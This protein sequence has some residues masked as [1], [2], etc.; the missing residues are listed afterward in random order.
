MPFDVPLELAAA[1]RADACRLCTR[2]PSPWLLSA[3][4]PTGIATAAERTATRVGHRWEAVLHAGIPYVIDKTAALV[5]SRDRAVSEPA[6]AAMREIVDAP[7]Y[8]HA[9]RDQAAEWRHAW[10]RMHLDVQTVRRAEQPDIQRAVNLHLF[11]VAQTLSRHTADADVGV[12]ARGLHGEGY[13]GHVFWDELFVFPFLNMRAPEITRALLLYRYRRLPEARRLAR[14][15][16]EGGALYPW[17]SGSD[18]R[19]ET[20]P[21]LFNPRS[22]TWM[23]DHSLLQFHVGLAVAYHT[24]HYYQVTG[25]VSFLAAHGAEI[26]V[27]T[28]RFWS[29]RAE[30]DPRSDRF[31]LRGMMGPDEFHDGGGHG[32]DDNAYVAVMTAWLMTTALRAHEVLAS[33]DTEEL[34]QRLDVDAAELE[35]WDRLRRRL[36]VPFLPNGLLAQF[37]GYADLADLDLAAY[38]DRYDGD[39]GRLDLIMAAEGDSPDR[40]KVSKQADVLMLFYLFSA[41]ELSGILQRLGYDFDPSTIPATIDYYL[42][43]TTHGSTLS[44]GVHAWVL[45]RSDRKR[46]WRLLREALDTELKDAQ[47]GSTREG[48]HLGAMAAT[49][50][51]LQR[52]F[53]GVEMR[54]DTIFL[55]PQLPDALR[56]V[57]FDLRYR[58]H[59]LSLEVTHDSLELRS[60]RGTAPPVRVVAD[61]RAEELRCGESLTRRRPAPRPS[62]A[63]AGPRERPI[64]L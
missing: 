14:S 27:D 54:E 44:R 23:P 41:E 55:H 60:R 31:H 5:T 51:I 13:R 45:A 50:D 8:A 58:G 39:I 18:G 40:Y 47:R 17:Q 56:K 37:D 1:E 7:A 43:R 21:A 63:R 32:V 46:A 59:W 10:Q 33:D 57:S 64:A 2:P 15:I 62:V 49:V 24:W 4:T 12:P 3:V 19:E 9:L 26:L 11:H 25:D 38:R 48:I 36:F 35:R 29:S 22:G 28:A 52:C 6:Y 42:D 30:Y 16:G 20:P 34:W 53:T 61:G